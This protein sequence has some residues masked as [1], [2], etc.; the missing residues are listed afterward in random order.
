[1][2]CPKTLGSPA[3][4]ALTSS[5]CIGLKSPEAPAYMTRSG[6]VRPLLQRSAPQHSALDV[7][8]ELVG[9]QHTEFAPQ[10]PLQHSGP[11][12]VVL[13]AWPTALHV[14]V[15]VV[16]VDV[17]DDVEVVPLTHGAP[18]LKVE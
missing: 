14:V 9:T 18:A 16:L 12:P 3:A 5:V 15:D 13:H 17:E 2:P 4:W 8:G 6:Q 11:P 1:M 7:H 10:V